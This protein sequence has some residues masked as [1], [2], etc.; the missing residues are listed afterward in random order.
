MFNG[1]DHNL[2]IFKK[3]DEDANSTQDSP[4]LFQWCSPL[5]P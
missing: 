4:F 3:K 2:I 1:V 5:L